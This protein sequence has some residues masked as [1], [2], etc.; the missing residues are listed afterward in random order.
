MFNDTDV[1]TLG[2]VTNA[3]QHVGNLRLF[4]QSYAEFHGY[5]SICVCLFGIVTNLFNI[6]GKYVSK[7]PA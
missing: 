4:A 7:Y 1:T 6:S 5:V 2:N 3:S